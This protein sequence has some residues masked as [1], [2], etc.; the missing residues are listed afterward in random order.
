MQPFRLRRDF[1]LVAWGPTLYIN[2]LRVFVA[3]AVW[4]L[5]RLCTGGAS[6]AAALAT[7]F[8]A[9][10]IYL[11]VFLPAYLI[12]RV[13]VGIMPNDSVG[14][15]VV[16]FLTLFATLGVIVADPI[17]FFIHKYK[18]RAVPLEKSSLLNFSCCLF[19]LDPAKTGHSLFN[20]P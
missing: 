12:I 4:G 17:L 19:V 7:P 18:P 3:G 8:M 10:L 2:F 5:I 6:P 15:M 14:E 1:R 11:F 9:V 16:G 13:I 20:V